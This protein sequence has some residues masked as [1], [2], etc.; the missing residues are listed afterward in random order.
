[1][2]LFKKKFILFENRKFIDLVEIFSV[3]LFYMIQS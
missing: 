3:I 1:M 2:Y